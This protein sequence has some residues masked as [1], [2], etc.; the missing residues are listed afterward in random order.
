LSW[1]RQLS[2]AVQTTGQR[3]MEDMERTCVARI[4][5]TRCIMFTLAL[6]FLWRVIGGWHRREA[7]ARFAIGVLSDNLQQYSSATKAYR[8]VSV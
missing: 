6:V 2:A 5:A 7:A 8:C 1:Q 3:R 4:H